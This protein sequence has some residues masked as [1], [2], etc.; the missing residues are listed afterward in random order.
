MTPTRQGREGHEIQPGDSG[1]WAT[2]ALGKEGKCVGDLKALF[3]EVGEG[4]HMKLS[5]FADQRSSFSSTHIVCSAPRKLLAKKKQRTAKS[6]P[7]LRMS[8]RTFVSPSQSRSLRQS[9]STHRAVSGFLCQLKV[10]ADRRIAVIFFK[11]RPPIDPVSLVRTIC[12]DIRNGEHKLHFHSV[13]RLTP[14]TL[15]GKASEHGLQD[16]A[17]RVLAP[18]FHQGG[19][20][21]KK[22][23]VC[24]VMQIT[25]PCFMAVL[26]PEIKSLIRE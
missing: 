23:R 11:T 25:H 24:S 9:S 18:H 17:R 12:E 21:E 6:R 3:E 2:C 8:S 20:S 19:S 4:R 7:R 1:I 22:V 10:V 14:M 13:K 26:R 15:I 16:I 5:S